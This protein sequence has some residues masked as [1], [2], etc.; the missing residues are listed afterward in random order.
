MKKCIQNVDVLVDGLFSGIKK[1]RI[2]QAESPGAPVRRNV[3]LGPRGYDVL[4]P[5][6]R[7][8]MK[9]WSF[10]VWLSVVKL[11][12]KSCEF[13][14]LR[15]WDIANVEPALGI[16]D[17]CLA[18]ASLTVSALCSVHVKTPI[19][20]TDSRVEAVWCRGV[21]C[22]CHEAPGGLD[23]IGWT[24]TRMDPLGLLPWNR[25]KGIRSFCLGEAIVGFHRSIGRHLHWSWC[26]VGKTSVSVGQ[27][28]QMPWC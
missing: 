15:C 12:L 26:F 17:W 5:I 3:G 24:R 27:Q 9:I 28:L 23:R 25:V 20:Q 6:F 11:S 13:D 8:Y 18:F 14:I 16:K 21:E 10:L 19:F 2:R 7:R 4:S 1:D 22:I